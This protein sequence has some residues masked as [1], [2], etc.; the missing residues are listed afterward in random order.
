MEATVELLGDFFIINYGKHGCVINM[1][2]SPVSHTD[3]LTA[4]NS[5][6]ATFKSED[7][8]IRVSFPEEQKLSDVVLLD[9]ST[10]ELHIARYI[11]S[12]H[13]NETHLWIG[14]LRV[15]E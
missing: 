1:R 8:K 3:L 12:T 6:T 15:V 10:T 11:R 13:N 5:K 4:I 7:G 9:K 2:K 14:G